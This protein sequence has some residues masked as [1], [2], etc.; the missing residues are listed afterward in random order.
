MHAKL[1][2]VEAGYT[3]TAKLLHWL[4]VALLIVQYAIAWNMPHIGRNTVPNTVINLHFSFGILILFVVILRLIWKWIRPEPTPIIGVPSWQIVAARLV[5]YALYLLLI[6]IPA[7]GWL[8]ASFRGFEVS[9][10]GLFT[11]PKLIATRAQVF[12]WTG[13]THIFVSQLH[14]AGLRLHNRVVDHLRRIGSAVDEV[15]NEDRLSARVTEAPAGLDVSE[16]LEQGLQLV[17]VPVYVANDVVTQGAL[18]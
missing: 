8:N 9:F 13:D 12:A 5:H 7:L 18:P 15:A 17:R 14:L 3:P 11:L 2:G 1:N 16:L 4:V 6:L 10:F